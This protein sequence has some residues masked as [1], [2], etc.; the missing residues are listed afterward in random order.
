MEHN[1]LQSSQST[2]LSHFTQLIGKLETEEASRVVDESYITAESQT[3]PM[4]CHYHGANAERNWKDLTL[5]LLENEKKIC[6]L[7]SDKTFCNAVVSSRELYSIL[8]PLNS[9]LEQRRNELE[10]LLSKTEN[11]INSKQEISRQ[12]SRKAQKQLQ[13][14]SYGL[15]SFMVGQ[16][17]E[18][19]ILRRVCVR[20]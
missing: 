7:S 3:I 13:F 17:S 11:E 14:A 15:G 6:R 19:S 5:C 20:A 16:V 12:V 8:D 2:L 4:T 10:E 18:L 9:A 1:E